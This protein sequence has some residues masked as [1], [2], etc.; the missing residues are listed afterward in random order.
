MLL[1]FDTSIPTAFNITD[2]SDIEI[3]MDDQFSHCRFNLLGYH[4]NAM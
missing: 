1:P 2:T 3:A 4:T